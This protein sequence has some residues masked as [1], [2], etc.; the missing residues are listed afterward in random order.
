M[1][2]REIVKKL[3]LDGWYQARMKGSHRV[4]KH[5]EKAGIVVVPPSVNTFYIKIFLAELSLSVPFI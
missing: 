4:F 3:E 2:V 1:K 5:P